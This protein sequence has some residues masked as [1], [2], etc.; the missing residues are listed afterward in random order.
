MSSYMLYSLSN[1]GFFVLQI[2]FLDKE[3]FSLKSTPTMSEASGR[4]SQGEFVDEPSK[5][6][7]SVETGLDFSKLNLDRR[8]TLEEFEA[9][10]SWQKTKPVGLDDSSKSRF[11][12]L[13]H[14]SHFEYVSGYLIPMPETPIEKEAVVLEIGRQLGNWNVE[15]GQNGVP[16]SSQGGFNFTTTGG[17]SIRAPDVAFTPK[18]TYRSLS[19]VQRRTFKGEPFCPTFVVEVEDTSKKAKLTALTAKFKETYFPAGVQLGWLIDPI[20]KK[21]FVFKRDRNGLVR[22]YSHGWSDVSGGDVLPGFLLKVSDIDEAVS[23]VCDI[24]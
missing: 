15:T 12:S 7:T 23:Q 8:Y 16:T 17:R 11:E 9:I 3:I 14:I 10:N 2:T 5:H 20:G 22:R 19:V 4:A 6:E 1:A 13:D 21:I 18:Q 24:S